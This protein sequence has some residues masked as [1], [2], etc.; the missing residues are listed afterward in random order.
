MQASLRTFPLVLGPE[1]AGSATVVVYWTGRGGALV[2]DSLTFAVNAIAREPLHIDIKSMQRK[3]QTL[4][5]EERLS[6]ARRYPRDV[7]QDEAALQFIEEHNITVLSGSKETVNDISAVF[8]DETETIVPTSIQ[9]VQIHAEL[10][11]RMEITDQLTSNN[12]SNFNEDISETNSIL[13]DNSTNI[14]NSSNAVHATTPSMSSSFTEIS[15][16]IL[17]DESQN[18]YNG[19]LTDNYT[20]TDVVS[21]T[22]LHLTMDQLVSASS[23]TAELLT[24]STINKETDPLIEV[25][26][27]QFINSSVSSNLGNSKIPSSNTT[28]ESFM[29][30]DFQTSS[31]TFTSELIQTTSNHSI[32]AD[33]EYFEALFQQLSNYTPQSY[34]SGNDSIVSLFN[35]TNNLT[36]NHETGNFSYFGGEND[37]DEYTIDTTENMISQISSLP[38]SKNMD[39]TSISNTTFDISNKTEGQSVR[40]NN[41]ISPK[42]VSLNNPRVEETF[43]E[44]LDEIKDSPEPATKLEFPPDYDSILSST[45]PLEYSSH[46]SFENDNIT[47]T[48]F[49]S[50][51]NAEIFEERISETT[52]DDLFSID[53][54]SED[55]MELR[56]H[57][58]RDLRHYEYADD[59]KEDVLQLTVRGMPGAHVSLSGYGDDAF[60]MLGGSEMSRSQVIHINITIITVV[61]HVYSTLLLTAVYISIGVCTFSLNI[62]RL[63]SKF[64]I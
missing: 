1:V 43:I 35:E 17:T 44:Y 11:D 13:D 46:E 12:V 40:M 24:L 9:D 25:F 10:P 38:M 36:I 19:S 55:Y 26:S 41:I 48:Y 59:I 61:L 18:D 31:E 54:D 63:L 4:D 6:F 62:F 33:E 28:T 42:L 29:T 5:K 51:I 7:D 20:V 47:A 49:P 50:N 22:K 39:S 32:L 23:T 37:L 60:N 15:S 8:I 57:R 21:T 45:S 2:A 53:I 64:D 16:D 30:S 3:K 27:D 52:S 34:S 56:D 58:R 14:Y